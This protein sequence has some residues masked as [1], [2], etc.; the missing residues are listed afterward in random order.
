M[1]DE[2]GIKKSNA[3][4]NAKALNF[5]L[6]TIEENHKH[7]KKQQQVLKELI[8]IVQD[9]VKQ[10]IANNQVVVVTQASQIA[11]NQVVVVTTQASKPEPMLVEPNQ[12][13]QNQHEC[14]AR[15][16]KEPELDFLD[17]EPPMV[18]DVQEDRVMLKHFDNE[19]VPDLHEYVVE[20]LVP[21][22]PEIPVLQ[23]NVKPLIEPVTA[24]ES[25]RLKVLSL[26]DNIL[27]AKSKPRC[28]S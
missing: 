6:D 22:E 3:K 20:S 16:H 2:E 13:Q 14:I 23:E 7:L 10:N 19:P 21:E 5:L 25:W 15:G 24:Y 9:K 18:H 12:V 17:I 28:Q 8:G 26:C 4:P 27:S 11:N 1:G